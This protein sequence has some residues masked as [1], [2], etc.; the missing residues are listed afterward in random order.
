MGATMTTVAALTKEVYGPKIVDQT[1][2]ETV[3]L[4][5]IEKTS[6]GTTSEAGGKYVTFPLKTRRN[7][8]IGYR[9]EL[10]ALQAPGQQGWQNVRVGLK[11]GYGRVHISGPTMSLAKEN[12]QAFASALQEEM[13]GLKNDII[14]DTNRILW[15]LGNGSLG[16]IDTAGAGVNTISLGTTADSVKY[17]DMDM[18]VD[19]LSSD[20]ST[21][22]ASNRKVTAI[23]F[24]TGDITVDGATFTVS[25]GDIV[26]RTGNY[27][28]EPNGLQ[29]LVK[30]TGTL[31]NLSPATEPLWAS[32]EDTAVGNLSESRMIAMCDKL[33]QN[34]GR[35]SV[36]FTD[37]GS[38]R[39]Y[40]NLLT[41]QRRFTGVQK[42]DGGFTGLAFAYDED[43]PLVTDIDAPAGAMWF[44]R[45]EDFKIYRRE[46][47]NWADMDGNIWKWVSGYDA[48]EALMVQYWEFALERRNTQGVMTGI[49]PG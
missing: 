26:V 3:L 42:F 17:I 38:R 40:F 22:R 29:S 24:S 14:K 27:G 35:P 25:I 47:W 49:T 8:G 45:E 46:P 41:T 37:L 13:D 48:W 7:A 34:G 23:N 12:F 28:K 33:R 4:K 16:S 10:E 20:G 18:Q 9:N 32:V 1:E 36:I 31:F 2:N 21:V 30:A 43:I 11:Y 5:R 6:Q 44:L 39:A 15:G 19:V